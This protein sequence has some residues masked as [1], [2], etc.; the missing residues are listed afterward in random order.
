M[1]PHPELSNNIEIAV[2]ILTISDIKKPGYTC[3]VCATAVGGSLFAGSFWKGLVGIRYVKI[4]AHEKMC[5]R[6]LSR[7][8]SRNKCV[9]KNAEIF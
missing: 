1:S 3:Q 7:I 8:I 5:M 4:R 6:N 9:S 2:A